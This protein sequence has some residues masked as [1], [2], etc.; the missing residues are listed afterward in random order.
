MLDDHV[1]AAQR[2]DGRCEMTKA[3]GDDPVIESPADTVADKA[4]VPLSDVR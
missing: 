4:H 3:S 1:S 2:L